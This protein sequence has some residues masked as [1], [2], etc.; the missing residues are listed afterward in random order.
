M[1]DPETDAAAIAAPVP[2]PDALSAP[3]LNVLP[4]VLGELRKA[5]AVIGA[6]ATPIDVA[7]PGYRG[8]LIARF[9]WVPVSD[10]AS[11]A[12]SLRAIKDATQQQLAAAAD[13]LVACNDEILVRVDD[14]LES[15]THE[16]LPV[17]FANGVGLTLALGLPK[18]TS[19][20]ECV[21]SVFGNEYGMVDVATKLMGWLE[22]TSREVDE[23]HLG[24]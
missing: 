15:L 2:A 8:M 18:P 24:E 6:G 5:R 13:A 11:T 9:R 12:K 1:L 10:L 7:I 14:K 19:A 16:G 22:D 3:D 20:R 23:A 21:F 4:S 17:T